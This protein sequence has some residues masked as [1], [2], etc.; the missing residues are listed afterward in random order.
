MLLIHPQS[1]RIEL[2]IS[3][4][5]PQIQLKW[6]GQLKSKGG[7]GLRSCQTS[8]SLS[9]RMDGRVDNLQNRNPIQQPRNIAVHAFNDLTHVSPIV[10]LY[11]LK[12]CYIRGTCKATAK[13]RAL[14]QQVHQA[15]Y[16]NPQPGP[17]IFVVRCLYILPVFES[18]CDGFSHLIIAAFRRFLKLGTTKED[19]KEARLLAAKLFV[20][21]FQGLLVHE[22]TII[23]K[24][25]EVFGVGFTDIEKIVQ[26]SDKSNNSSEKAIELTRQYINYLMDSHSYLNAVS[27]IEQFSLYQFGESFLHR[28]I[29]E[30]QYEA[31]DR[32][33]MFMGKPMSRLLVQAYVDRKLLKRAYVIIKKNNLQ[34]EYP[35]ICQDYR[36]S[37]LKKLAEKGCWDIAEQ[38]ANGDQRLLQYLVYMALE[39]GYGEKVEELCNRYSLEGFTDTKLPK[40]TPVKSNFLSLG[41]LSVEEIV[42]VDEANGLLE[43]TCNIEDS[44]VVGIDCEW[45][46]NYIKGQKNKVSIMQIAAG[47]KVYILDMIKLYNA[48]PDALEDCITRIFQSP[49]ILKLGYNLQS[50]IHQLVHSYGKMQ[51]F[52]R[53]EMLLDIQNIFKEPRGG[54]SGLAKKILGAGLNKTRRNSNWES[55]PLSQYQLEYAALDA[56]VL[57]HIF[58]HVPSNSRPAGFSD[59]D[60][61]IGWKSQI[62]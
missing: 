14:M 16:N 61:N 45:K 23:V 25:L 38:R 33:V 40:T 21:V 42:F 41:D 46:P 57:I 4:T 52:Q 10:F 9:V 51:C 15:L 2:E 58:R 30:K 47:N 49:S 32:W 8:I 5:R 22:E 17:A 44:K 20:D 1:S 55:R 3:C 62:V 43:A 26:N 12:E 36:E 13:F 39:S 29:E 54:L 6:T 59:G 48:I 27:V 56:A 11:L 50:D 18:Y 28:I 35:E 7:L 53:Y 60:P 19:I 34:H 24:V 31:A 37:S